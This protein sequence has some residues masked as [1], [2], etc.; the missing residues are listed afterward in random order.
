MYP[1]A[2][3]AISC[4]RISRALILTRSPGMAAFRFFR[5]THLTV[6]TRK[7]FL[8]KRSRFSRRDP[9]SRPS[10]MKRFSASPRESGAAPGRHTAS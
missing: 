10:S 4:P 5:K 3:P 9:P 2:R 6:S 1:G 7:K 8:A